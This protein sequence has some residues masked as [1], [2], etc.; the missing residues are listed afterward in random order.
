M[1]RLDR[2][3]KAEIIA[4]L[5]NRR[6]M[7]IATI[8]QDGWPQ[9]TAVS[10]ANEGLVLY[11]IIGRNSQKFLNIVR[12]PRVSVSIS[13]DTGLA[14]LYK[15]LSMGG[16]AKVLEGRAQIERIR[17]IVVSRNPQYKHFLAPDLM[18][19]AVVCFKPEVVSV[20]DYSK[21]FGHSAL[22]HVSQDQEVKLIEAPLHDWI[23][24]Q[25]AAVSGRTIPL[26]RLA[27]PSLSPVQSPAN[28]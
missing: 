12:D 16:H 22:V 2:D 26:P 11:S 18:R 9:A 28:S 10:Y 6:L 19:I 27:S 1:C 3:L 25:A 7:T 14:L 20:T 21:G 15:G 8:R 4:Q 24:L 23:G 5:N 17:E 13:D